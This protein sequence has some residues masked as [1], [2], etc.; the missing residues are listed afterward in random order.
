MGEAPAPDTAGNRKRPLENMAAWSSAVAPYQQPSN[1]RA[2]WQIINSIGAYVLAW[3]LMYF[4]VDISWWL[5]VPLAV[6]TAGLQIRIFIIFHDCGHGSFLKSRRANSFWGFI[7][8]MLTFTPYYRWR[9]EH[10]RH[11]LRSG[12][13]DHRGIGDIWTMTVQEYLDAPR[14]K[15]FNYRL[16]RDPLILF[17]VGAMYLTL[18]KERFPT[19]VGK[20]REKWSVFYLHFV[21]S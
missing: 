2:T 9:W 10:N 17:I 13:L 4:A 3:I 21:L 15:R 18:I 11:H 8:G 14:W 7:S 12:N 1:L 16:S 5:T 6:V 19:K 20:G